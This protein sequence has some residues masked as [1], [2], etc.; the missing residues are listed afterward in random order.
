[1]GGEPGRQR[2]RSYTAP[3]VERVGALSAG[4]CP[5]RPA[6]ALGSRCL[7]G[8][9][10]VGGL[11]LEGPRLQGQLCA[12]LL[13]TLAMLYQTFSLPKTCSCHLPQSLLSGHT[14]VKLETPGVV[15][16]ASASKIVLWAPSRSF[17]IQW[18]ISIHF[19]N[20]QPESF[21]G[22]RLLSILLEPSRCSYLL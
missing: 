14:V 8:G 15:Y 20:V 3:E 9:G 12:Q 16:T 17:P 1:M 22:R 4:L 10:G 21:Q 2:P 6:G 11:A 5:S 19:S 13:L 18:D 7:P